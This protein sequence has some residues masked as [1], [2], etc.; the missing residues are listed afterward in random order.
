MSL[1]PDARTHLL[2][3]G[4]AEHVLPLVTQPKFDAAPI[5]EARVALKLLREGERGLRKD[6]VEAGDERLAACVRQGV[7]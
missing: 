6:V 2:G 4:G 7:Y 5:D 1:V 3:L